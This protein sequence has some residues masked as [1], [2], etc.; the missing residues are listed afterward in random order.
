MRCS[1]YKLSC[2]DRA[3]DLEVSVFSGIPGWEAK[4]NNT[5]EEKKKV[6]DSTIE[7]KRKYIYLLRIWRKNVITWRI[8]I[9]RKPLTNDNMTI[10]TPEKADLSMSVNTKWRGLTA[11]I[12]W[13]Q[14]TRHQILGESVDENELWKYGEMAQTQQG[15]SEISMRRNC[16]R[17]W[18]LSGTMT[19]EWSN[20]H[21]WGT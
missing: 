15:E 10:N 21:R 14:T 7:A 9:A 11:L 20:R 2:T 4:K 19:W 18:R 12:Q 13:V 5:E 6:A 8:A 17:Q 16:N 3:R 1:G